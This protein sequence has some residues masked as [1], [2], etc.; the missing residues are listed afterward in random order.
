MMAEGNNG[1]RLESTE[2]VVFAL[3]M[4]CLNFGAIPFNLSH[5]PLSD[6]QRFDL[7]GDL[8]AFAN[9]VMCDSIKEMAI[10]FI[11]GLEW[12]ERMREG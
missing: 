5:S 3:F 9:F 7:V 12:N 2:P 1:L 6:M 10:N 11:Q 4:D 8:Y